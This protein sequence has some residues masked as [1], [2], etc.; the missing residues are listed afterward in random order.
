MRTVVVSPFTPLPLERATD[1]V[2]QRLRMFMSAVSLISDHIDFVG[3][4]PEQD[5]AAYPCGA[6]LDAALSDYWRVPVHVTLIPT[7]RRKETF[8]NHYVKGIFRL[9]EQPFFHHFLGP[10][11]TTALG[12]IL[13]AD[14]DL[15]F[16]FRLSA[17]ACVVRTGVVPR[18]M[19]FDL[20]DV[21]HTM[22]LRTALERPV[23]PGKAVYLAH[24][25]AILAS[26]LRIARR[27]QAVFVCSE[28]DARGLRRLGF[29]PAVTVAPNALPLP[30]VPSPLASGQNIL[31]I[32]SYGYKPNRD[33][34]ER[35]VTTIWPLI[36]ARA[37]SARLIIAGKNPDLI[38][39]FGDPPPGVEFTGFVQNLQALYERARCVV[40]PLML[41]G[42]TR[43]KL[44]EAGAY[45]KPMV[46]TPIGSEGLAFQD[47]ASI[48]LREDDLGFSA[49]CVQLLDDDGLCS[50]LG[51]AARATVELHY[52]VRKVEQAVARVLSARTPG[53]VL[54][55]GRADT[56]EL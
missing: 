53:G 8:W 44:I 39:G 41:G 1:G 3:L 48:I 47:G 38:R 21:E 15:V 34:A 55:A 22:R 40:C 26:E 29:G 42:G 36:R 16:A 24:A 9:S 25:P 31:F 49:A 20:D 30:P 33:A 28:L 19:S 7:A 56:A 50:R 45:G 27:S 43:I 11:Q 37:P 6:A 5:A 13:S 2:F 23:W 52:D 10:E 4:V 51:A 18:R 54:Q 17:A 46:S 14:P 35:L 32:G 12:R